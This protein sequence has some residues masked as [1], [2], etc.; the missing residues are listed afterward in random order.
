MDLSPSPRY[1]KRPGCAGYARRRIFTSHRQYQTMAR[2]VILVGTESGNAQMVADVLKD[3]I[4]GHDVA[5]TDRA[6]S[7]ADLSGYEIALICC[8]THGNGDI[9]TNILGLAEAL[10]KEKPDLSA[11]RYGV[12]ALGDQTYSDTFCFGGKK[13]DAIFAACGAQKIGERLEIDAC[14][15]PLPDEEAVQWSKDWVTLL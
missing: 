5:V 7:A 8:A 11:L 15:Q 1:Q 10:E 3:E 9:P 4:V 6:Q 2:I 13:M 12:I 14:T